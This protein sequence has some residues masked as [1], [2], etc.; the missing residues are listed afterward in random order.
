MATQQQLREQITRQ[1]VTALE[2][3]NVPPWRRPWRLGPNAGFPAKVVSRKAYRRI[4]PILLEMATTRHNLTSKWWGTF[5][6]WKTLGGKVMPRPPHV[7]PGQWGT[8]IVFWSPLV[9]TIEND[10]GE[11]ERDK[12]RTDNASRGSDS[13]FTATGS[14]PGRSACI[15]TLCAGWWWCGLPFA[16]RG[17]GSE[18]LGC[19]RG[20]RPP[21]AF[22]PAICRLFP[23]T[24]LIGSPP[25]LARGSGRASEPK[26]RE[27]YSAPPRD[28]AMRCRSEATEAARCA[29]GKTGAMRCRS[30]RRL[31]LL[32]YFAEVP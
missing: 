29:V 25:P 12:L 3:G 16:G 23:G 9:K 31:L 30:A 22:L 11:E 28:Y 15:A 13:L 27:T 18:A 24:S 26:C 2:F 19:D 4:N 21:H 6:Q 10:Q 1:I 17:Q 8:Q 20:R 14:P 7:T 5:N 32:T